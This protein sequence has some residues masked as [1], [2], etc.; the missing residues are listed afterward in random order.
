[1]SLYKNLRNLLDEFDITQK[2]LATELNIAPSTL[3]GYMQG[4]SQPDFET[5]K[6]L[7]KYFNVS[8]DYLLDF[9]Y[10]TKFDK[11]KEELLRIFNGL[12]LEQKE[13]YIEQGKAILKI[14]RKKKLLK[15][16][17]KK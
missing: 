8:I 1:M 10:E 6:S 16:N 15:K 14:Q 13:L 2:Q 5:L 7:A 4:T 11:Q 17:I 3:S 9:N 12:S